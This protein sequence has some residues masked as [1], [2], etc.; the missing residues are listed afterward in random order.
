VLFPRSPT[1]L[2]QPG[3]RCANLCMARATRIWPVLVCFHGSW[4]V[5]GSETLPPTGETP[6]LPRSASPVLI[7]ISRCVNM[8]GRCPGPMYGKK[9]RALPLPQNPSGT[10]S[11]YY[12]GSGRVNSTPSRAASIRMALPFAAATARACSTIAVMRASS[13]PGS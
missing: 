6:V 8:Q 12:R 13:C 11:E 5:R 7:W 10:Y 2:H 1:H 4:K 9:Q 3:A